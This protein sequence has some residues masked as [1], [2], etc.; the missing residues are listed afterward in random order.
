[1]GPVFSA[2][3]NSHIFFPPP[4][5]AEQFTALPNFR[6]LSTPDGQLVPC[7]VHLPQKRS[8]S[9]Y[10]VFSHGNATDIAQMAEYA[11]YLAASTG[12]AVV[13]YDYIGY[14]AA[15][16]RAT[17]LPTEAGCYASLAAVVQFLTTEMRID[18]SNIIL[19]GQSLGTGVVVGFAAARRWVA[20]IML[21][22]PYKSICRVVVDS[23][24]VDPIDRFVSSEKMRRLRCPVKI[25]HGDSDAVIV[26]GH[27]K[28]LYRLTPE[29]L[30]MDPVWL[31]GVGHNDILRAL[32][33]HHFMDL[34]RPL[35]GERHGKIGS[36][37]R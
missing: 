23:S 35:G 18:A 16:T 22:S 21:V 7:C 15:V 13:M 19:V 6:V 1:M 36:P 24:L 9:R 5:P 27:G 2:T 14:G 4:T 29:L 28:E 3:V 8:I 34:F 20:P 26:I 37:G 12:A 11:R 10:I 33:S 25:C 17:T 32:E 30:R 31:A